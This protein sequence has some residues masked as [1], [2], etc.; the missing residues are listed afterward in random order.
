MKSTGSA[1]ASA[2]MQSQCLALD[3]SDVRLCRRRWP[4]TGAGLAAAAARQSRDR[5]R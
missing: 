1:M 2:D 4:G 5:Y 3:A